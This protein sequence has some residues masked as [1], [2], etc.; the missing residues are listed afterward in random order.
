MR[1]TLFATALAALLVA[2]PAGAQSTADSGVPGG[3]SGHGPAH[4]L[5]PEQAA[6]FAKQ[7]ER[8]LA[9]RNAHVAIVFRAGRPRTDL[10]D[11]IAY[12]HGA[13]WV[14]GETTGA[15]GKTYKGYAV[16]NLYQGDANR[17]RSTNPTWPATT[18]STSSPARRPT[19]SG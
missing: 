12:T 5:R 6:T 3:F 19:M 10:P 11:N 9:M 1:R 18:R 17:C 13:F 16:Y 2:A 7:V 15:D 4:H 8:D 14:Y